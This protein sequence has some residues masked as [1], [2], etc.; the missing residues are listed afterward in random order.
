MLL[1]FILLGLFFVLFS[2]RSASYDSNQL[3]T[4]IT[5]PGTITPI[6][7]NTSPNALSPGSTPGL[8]TNG[9]RSRE[10]GV[11]E[12][13]LVSYGFIKCADREGRLFFHYS[14][15]HGEAQSLHISGRF[16]VVSVVF[17][18]TNCTCRC[19]MQTNLCA[20]GI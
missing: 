11:I 8:S 18:A 14:Q 6:S 2:Q 19:T 9:Y 3:L 1:L 7:G 10:T 20:F 4:G 13:L 12:K 5:N 15:F 16:A 17:K